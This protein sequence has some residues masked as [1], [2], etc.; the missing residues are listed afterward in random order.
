MFK[1]TNRIRVAPV[2]LSEGQSRLLFSHTHL[3]PNQILVAP[4]EPVARQTFL[5]LP[6]PKSIPHYK[7]IPTKSNY[8]IFMSRG[9][10]CNPSLSPS[11]ISNF[12][13]P[14]PARSTWC[15]GHKTTRRSYASNLI[16]HRLHSIMICRLPAAAHRDTYISVRTAL[17]AS[18][19]LESHLPTASEQ[20]VAGPRTTAE[21]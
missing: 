4:R 8:H 11:Y 5:L 2:S 1:P 9:R 14:P 19:S 21:L 7:S 3:V 17:A 10:P 12:L 20:L 6:S 16:L 15:R 18:G 13:I